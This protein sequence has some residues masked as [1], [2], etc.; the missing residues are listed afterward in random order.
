MLVLSYLFLVVLCIHWV[1]DKSFTT[2]FIVKYL[3]VVN[4]YYFLK[5]I[6]LYHLK[7]LNVDV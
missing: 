1:A 6:Y 2:L 7:I 4:A 3:Y 5:Q